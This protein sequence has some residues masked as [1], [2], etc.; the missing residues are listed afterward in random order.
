MPRPA[1]NRGF[2]LAAALC[3]AGFGCG[4]THA[5]SESKI[6]PITSFKQVA[7]QWEGLSKRMP[8]MR[9]HA[10][11]VLIINDRGHF[12]FISDRGSGLLLGTGT[13]TILNGQASGSSGSGTGTLTL[14]EEAGV[15]VLVLDA[16]LN[17]GH[18]YYVEM[19]RM[20]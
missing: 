15:S 17:D 11:V 14:H 18:H 10:Q 5:R 12:N 2:F 19:T 16:A 1:S 8:D 7:G 20:K 9:E 4:T 13:L 6:V 3:V